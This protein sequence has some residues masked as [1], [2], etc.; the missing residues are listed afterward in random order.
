MTR[1]INLLLVLVLLVGVGILAYP[2]ISDQFNLMRN[3]RTLQAYTK[4]VQDMSADVYSAMLE[5]AKLYNN[6]LRGVEI[7][8]AFTEAGGSKDRMYLGL[9]NLNGIMGYVEIPKIGVRLPIFHTTESYGLERGVGHMEG[10][11]LPIGGKG[12]HVGLSGH[13]GLPSARLFSDLDQLV[14]GDLFYLSVLGDTMVY[15]VEEIL[16]VLPTELDPMAVQPGR[17]LVT[18]VTCTPYGINTHRLLVRGVRVDPID[19]AEAL[20]ATDAV[21]AMPLWECTL[22][23]AA[24]VALI[25]LLIMIITS[26][27]KKPARL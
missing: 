20:A 3:E 11:S 9:L 21:I 25:L 17:D 8:D 2:T 12:N 24:P 4:D 23:A 1:L 13:R 22:I 7:H 26:P 27:G 15:Q 10:T 16:V 14:E 5:A 19:V 6:S 18:L